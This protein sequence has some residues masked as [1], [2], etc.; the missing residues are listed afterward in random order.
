[1]FWSEIKYIYL[2]KFEKF[3]NRLLEIEKGF[4]NYLCF[5]SGIKSH[6]LI[7]IWNLKKTFFV[8]DIFLPKIIVKY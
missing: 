3:F 5:Y 4:Q 8:T 2:D 1:M 7:F 6:W